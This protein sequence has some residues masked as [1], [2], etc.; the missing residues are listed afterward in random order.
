MQARAGRRHRRGL[1]WC[2]ANGRGVNDGDLMVWNGFIA[3]P[4]LDHIKEK[5][6]I[7]DGTDIQT[8]QT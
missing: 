4:F 3:T 2:Y 8:I 6:N 7:T 1:E 5:K